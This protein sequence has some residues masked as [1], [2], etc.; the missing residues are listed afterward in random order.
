M[1]PNDLSRVETAVLELNEQ[2]NSIHPCEAVVILDTL[3]AGL[4]FIY[5]L[6]VHTRVPGIVTVA[7]D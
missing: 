3:V 4:R 5:E 2:D 7:Q 6:R 1:L